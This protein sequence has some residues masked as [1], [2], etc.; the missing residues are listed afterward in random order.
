MIAEIGKESGFILVDDVAKELSF[1]QTHMKK[2]IECGE[3]N[4]AIINGS[5]YMTHNEV[6]RFK[7]MR[8]DGREELMKRFA[9]QDDIT[10][11]AA[12]EIAELLK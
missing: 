9:E 7:K 11:K 1:S 2:L 5:V 10:N 8:D 3:V 4:V 6:K 12:A